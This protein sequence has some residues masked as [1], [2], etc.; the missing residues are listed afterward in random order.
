M[1]RSN[2]DNFCFL[3]FT[4]G[5]DPVSARLTREHMECSPTRWDLRCPRHRN[6]RR[7][8]HIFNEN[9]VA[10]GGIVDED[11]GDSSY[12][13]AVLDDGRAAHECVQEGTIFNR[14]FM[15]IFILG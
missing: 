10:R 13:L 6:L 4:V 1:V 9:S 11:V 12:E 5:A 7:G 14:N 8:Q 15:I 3:H 2:R